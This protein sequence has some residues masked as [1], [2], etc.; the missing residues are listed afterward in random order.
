M[1]VFRGFA[2]FLQERITSEAR[3]LAG[4]RSFVNRLAKGKP[5]ISN[6]PTNRNIKVPLHPESDFSAHSIERPVLGVEAD[7]R[8]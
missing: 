1:Y 2:P 3:P 4:I 6:E 7:L 8:G 5:I